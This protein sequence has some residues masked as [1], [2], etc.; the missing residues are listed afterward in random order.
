MKFVEI[1][2]IED[3]CKSF[4]KYLNHLESKSLF[5]LHY[6]S[7]EFGGE[8][9]DT[10]SDGLARAAVHRLFTNAIPLLLNAETFAH[11]VFDLGW[12]VPHYRTWCTAHSCV[13]TML[14]LSLLV[15]LQ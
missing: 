13:V 6:L 14:T 3:T 7:I 10:S 9:G 15:P 8:K 12:Y 5:P 1:Y 4:V 11:C 2:S